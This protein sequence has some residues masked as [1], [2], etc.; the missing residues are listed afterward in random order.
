MITPNMLETM[1]RTHANFCKH[2]TLMVT[3]A[4][5][6]ASEA[7]TPKAATISRDGLIYSNLNVH[8][9]RLVN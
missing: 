9:L 6:N 3:H 8:K 4:A 2:G 5:D 1:R 7:M